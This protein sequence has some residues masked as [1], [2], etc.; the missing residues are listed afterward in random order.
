MM[1]ASQFAWRCC[2][3]GDYPPPIPKRG[4]RYG[5][6]A[7]CCLC[8]GAT[9]GVGWHRKDGIAPPIKPIVARNSADSSGRSFGGAFVSAIPARPWQAD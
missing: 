4:E 3:A 5:P 7:I 6:D 2:A 9:G 8:G 1:T